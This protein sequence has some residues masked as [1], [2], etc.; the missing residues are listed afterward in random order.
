MTCEL[1]RDLST[2]PVI[3]AFQILWAR[4]DFCPALLANAVSSP[5][6]YP[7]RRILISLL[8]LL[9]PGMD[10]GPSGS[11]R[12]RAGNTGLDFFKLLVHSFFSLAIRPSLCSW[13][14]RIRELI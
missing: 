11:T 9:D 4:A 6:H 1:R 2:T 10:P 8:H 13:L 3:E 12:V 5:S 7:R 14:I